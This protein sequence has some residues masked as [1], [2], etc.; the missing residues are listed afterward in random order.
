MTILE[1]ICRARD[2]EQ[3]LIRAI[4]AFQ[5]AGVVG[6]TVISIEEPSTLSLFRQLQALRADLIPP[7][8]AHEDWA[9]YRGA[10]ET[11]NQ[12]QAA[13]AFAEAIDRAAL[14]DKVRELLDRSSSPGKVVS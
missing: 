14:P 7:P 12:L 9:W 8:G 10:D 4:A 2:E 5:D 11:P 3:G 6:D 13:L 1:A